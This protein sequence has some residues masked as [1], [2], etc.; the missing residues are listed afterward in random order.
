MTT[1]SQSNF[2]SDLLKNNNIKT[3]LDIGANVGN[4]SRMCK[5]ISPDVDIVMIEGN[6]NCEHNLRNTGI[7]YYIALLSDQEKEVTFYVNK[8]NP[9]C[10]GASYYKEIT[11]SYTDANQI[12]INTVSLDS[13]LSD[14]NINF[15]LVK[16]DVQGAELDVIRGGKEIISKSSFVFCECPYI[17]TP[18]TLKYN[19]NSCTLNEI[20]DELKTLGFSNYEEVENLC[21]YDNAIHWESGTIVA[22]DVLFYK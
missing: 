12:K 2:I 1:P 6:P 9:V 16:I 21:V 13:L 7:K 18:D 22:K 3:I 14:I 19:E 15:D 17:E 4:F 5:N 8:S 10:T 20:I 11:D